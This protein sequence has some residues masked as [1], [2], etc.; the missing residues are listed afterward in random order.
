MADRLTGIDL[1]GV[2]GSGL[3]DWGRKD[4]A[5][6]IKMLRAKAADD[7]ATAE[8]ILAASDADFHIQTYVGVHRRRQVEV[9]QQGRAKDN[10]HG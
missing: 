6:M 1:P 7:K 8:K 2:W 10:N 5:E 4:P 9:L 3:A